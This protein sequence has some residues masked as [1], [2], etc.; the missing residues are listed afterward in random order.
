MANMQELLKLENV[1]IIDSVTGWAEAIKASAQPLVDQGYAEPRY[2]DAMIDAVV[3]IGPYFVLCPGVAM[4]HARPEQGALGTQMSALLLRQPVHF[5]EDAPGV[6]LFITLIAK[7]SDS[8]LAALKHLAGLLG[9]RSNVDALLAA[10]TP[11]ELYG[12]LT[13]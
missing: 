11:E 2:I 13:N 9:E 3:N 8:H 12:L 4:P 5:N 1:Q 10:Q 6:S 7:D